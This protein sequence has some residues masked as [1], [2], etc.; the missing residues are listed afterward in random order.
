MVK[1][2]LS[3]Y[4]VVA[5]AV[6]LSPAVCVGAVGVPVKAGETSITKVD[7]VPV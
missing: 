3:T 1:F 7:P 2:S 5:T 6:E 4:A